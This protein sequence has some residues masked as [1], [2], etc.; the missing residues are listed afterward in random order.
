MKIATLGLV[1]SEDWNKGKMLLLGEKKKGEIGTGRL[2]GPGG[3]LDPY[4]TIEGCLIRETREE[5]DLNLEPKSL[6]LVAYI[7]FH[8]G[9]TRFASLNRLLNIFNLG[10]IPDFGVYVYRA[11]LVQGQELKETKDMF[12]P[13]WYPLSDVPYEKM[14]DGDRYW[15]QSAALGKR[16]RANVYYLNRAE[17]FSHI[18]FFPFN[19]GFD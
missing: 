2:S 12:L 11:R 16:F 17:K 14:Y 9:R 4:E 13:K 6:E 18:K 10:G 7:V 8:K 3:K 5:L 1:L 19:K 15:L